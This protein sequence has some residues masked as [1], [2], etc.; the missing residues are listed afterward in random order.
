MSVF[1]SPFFYILPEAGHHFSEVSFPAAS[2][3]KDFSFAGF[4]SLFHS[5]FRQNPFTCFD[6][7]FFSLFQRWFFFH[8]SLKLLFTL[9]LG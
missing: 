1:Q 4:F 5:A 8:F 9:F 3:V 6:L 2:N 7:H